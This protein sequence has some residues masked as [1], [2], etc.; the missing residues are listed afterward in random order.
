[1]IDIR[2]HTEREMAPIYVMGH[3]DPLAFNR[4]RNRQTITIQTTDE[5][6]EG[7]IVM[8]DEHQLY[9]LYDKLRE[10]FHPRLVRANDAG[11]AQTLVDNAGTNRV[12]PLQERQDL[13]NDLLETPQWARTY[14][15]PFPTDLPIEYVPA[16]RHEGQF[17]TR[18]AIEE[19][20]REIENTPIQPTQV[21]MT[22]QQLDDIRATFN[23]QANEEPMTPAQR[24]VDNYYNTVPLR[25]YVPGTYTNMRTLETREIRI[26]CEISIADDPA[27]QES[28]LEFMEK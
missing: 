11:V 25:P 1:M 4:G 23:T 28:I 20:M 5:D 13:V 9:R 6:G 8:S 10:H 21:V 15:A 2:I 19:A 7:T 14:V 12:P 18:E 16:Q 27:D 3:V 17:F 22:Q 24:A 26:D